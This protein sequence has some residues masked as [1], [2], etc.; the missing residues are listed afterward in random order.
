MLNSSSDQHRYNLSQYYNTNTIIPIHKAIMNGILTEKTE[1]NMPIS[2]NRMEGMELENR[3]PK[4]PP[5]KLP[6]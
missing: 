2:E 5:I 1:L 6:R 4:T 3:V